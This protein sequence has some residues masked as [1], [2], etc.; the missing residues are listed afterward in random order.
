LIFSA[1]AAAQVHRG[2]R[3]VR[4]LP[5]LL[6]GDLGKLAAAIADIDAPQ[7]GHGV[8]VA[9]AVGFEDGRAFAARDDHLLGFQRLVLNDGVQDVSQVLLH[10]GF[11][12]CR[13]GR[14]GKRHVGLAR[15][16]AGQMNTATFTL[17]VPPELAGVG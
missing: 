10:H 12:Y 11:A 2:V 1:S 3:E 4:Q 8:E 13:I 5:H 6:R 15:L 7:P 9:R 16:A 17:Q 14:V